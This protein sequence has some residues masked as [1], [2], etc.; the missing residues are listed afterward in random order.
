METKNAK[1]LESYREKI[2][3]IDGRILK[4]FEEN[5]CQDGELEEQSKKMSKL[6]GLEADFLENV[7]KLLKEYRRKIKDVE[8][9][10]FLIKERNEV[11]RDIARYKKEH[12]LPVRVMGRELTLIKDRVNQANHL[13]SA[14][15]KSLFE[16]ILAQSRDVQE[17][18]LAELESA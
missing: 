5:E 2:D 9:F 16:A 17:K 14:F 4:Q 3:K 1:Q 6:E 8:H 11:A 13:P 7:N 10:S 15:V 12:N 18:L